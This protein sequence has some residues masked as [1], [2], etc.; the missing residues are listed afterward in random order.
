MKTSENQIPWYSEEAGFFSEWYFSVV[1][2]RPKDEIAPHECDFLEKVLNLKKG[3][4][5]LDLCCGHGRITTELARRGYIMTGQDVNNYFL[6]IAGNKAREEN[7]NIN[8]IKSDMRRIPYQNEFDAV[9]NMFTSFGFFGSDEEDEKVIREV[10]RSLK[11]NGKFVM[12]YVN[13][14]FIIRKYMTEDTR[15]IENGYV[16]IK[17]E[18]DHIKSSHLDIFDIYIND[19]LVKHFTCDFR[20]YSVTELTSMFKRNGFRTLDVYGNFEFDPL[21]FDSKGCIIIAEKISGL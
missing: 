8:Y 3:S 16:K 4:K 1:G 6:D 15:K 21:S 18:Y 2:I 9:L 7:L 12:D 11:T 14:D 13:K 19:K 10:S 5:I 17:R 20:F